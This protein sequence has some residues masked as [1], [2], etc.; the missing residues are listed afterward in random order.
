MAGAR[1]KFQTLITQLATTF[2][3]NNVGQITPAILRDFL[4]SFLRTAFEPGAV[5]F[6]TTPTVVNLTNAW[7]VIPAAFWTSSGFDA[8]GDISADQALG[9]LNGSTSLVGGDYLVYPNISIEGVVNSPVEVGIFRTGVAPTVALGTCTLGGAGRPVSV[10][11]SNW[12]QG[13]GINEYFQL[14]LRSPGGVLA[15]TVNV[16]RIRMELKNTWS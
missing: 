14:G 9:R 15:P 4:D 5:L 10:F 16:A 3:D 13:V 11:F 6:G 2:P 12:Y 1:S 7:S 8:S